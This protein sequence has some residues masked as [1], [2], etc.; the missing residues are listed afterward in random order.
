MN[1]LTYSG[2]GLVF[3]GL[4]GAAVFFFSGDSD[5]AATPMATGTPASSIVASPAVEP[6]SPVSPTPRVPTTP[7]GSVRTLAGGAGRAGF[8]DGP[9]LV[10]R[11]GEIGDIV[12][13]PDGAIFVADTSN[14][15]IRKV[16][17]AGNVTTIAGTGDAGAQD[18]PAASATFNGP[19]G[20]ALGVDGSVFVADT[21]NH[22]IRV[23]SPGGEV[24]TLAGGGEPG[25]GGGGFVDG[26]LAN[27]LFRLPKDIHVDGNRVYISDTGN[28]R[29]RIIREN[30][31]W[32]A[33]GSDGPGSTDGP[34]LNAAF[35]SNAGVA[36]GPG[37]NLFIMDQ[38]S[39]AVRIL[40]FADNTLQTADTGLLLE[41]PF[42]LAFAGETML[43][44]DTGKHR[45]VS[46][47][48]SN[49]LEVFIAGSDSPGYRDGPAADAQ[50]RTPT[51]IAVRADGS[52]VVADSGNN[53]LR[54]IE[55]WR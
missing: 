41:N 21:L 42:T 4:A 50:F 11:F 28:R 15:A 2:I 7:V 24:W 43:I 53:V 29:I 19:V 16:D 6:S 40:G 25:M 8:V 48:G 52:I 54:V 34:A 26:L 14:N 3:A 36:I 12:V 49:H 18:G 51:G 10:A 44:A 46:P 17:S 30:V 27:V 38:G 37:G 47:A 45:I 55:N 32:T 31:A 22:K 1:L 23:I 13:A 33:A 39:S 5:S 35:G 9:A 20:V